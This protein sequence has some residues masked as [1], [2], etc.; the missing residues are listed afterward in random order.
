MLINYR[1]V[2]KLFQCVNNVYIFFH[3]FPTIMI[4]LQSGFIF[5]AILGFCRPY[6]LS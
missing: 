3:N 2:D 5:I 1:N 6:H 4:F